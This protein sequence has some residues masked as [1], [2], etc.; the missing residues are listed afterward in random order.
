[1]SRE[2][3]SE[4]YEELH[5]SQ[6]IDMDLREQ[7]ELHYEADLRKLEEYN[8]YTEIKFHQYDSRCELEREYREYQKSKYT[9]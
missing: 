3:F 8:Y 1:M 6:E 7:A 5:E 2:L 9:Y 4:I